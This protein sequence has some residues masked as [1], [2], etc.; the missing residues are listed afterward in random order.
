MKNIIGMMILGGTGY[1]FAIEI[2]NRLNLHILQF[3]Q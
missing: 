3:V 2:A 1:Y